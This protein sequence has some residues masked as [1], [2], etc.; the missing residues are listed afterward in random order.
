V[1]AATSVSSTAQPTRRTHGLLVVAGILQTAAVLT[2]AVR[3]SL[4]GTKPFLGVQTAGP[5]LIVLGLI[6]IAVAFRPSAWWRWIPA[7]LSA[8]VVAL[9][10]WRVVTAPSGTFADVALR[11]AVHPAWGF[12]PM[13]AAVAVNLVAAVWM[14]RTRSLPVAQLA[15]K[16]TSVQPSDD[17]AAL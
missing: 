15:Q 2:P 4:V 8:A 6:T 16:I 13:C 7:V 11:H 14:P 5:V 3:I 9:V 1:T 17:D 10:Y 12:I